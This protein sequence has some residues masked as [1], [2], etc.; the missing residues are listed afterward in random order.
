[1]KWLF[2]LLLKKS[3]ISC[4]D[5]IADREGGIVLTKPD[6]VSN[7]LW[8]FLEKMPREQFIPFFKTF[9]SIRDTEGKT[10]LQNFTILQS[11][12]LYFDLPAV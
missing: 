8:L 2:P 10:F 9:L 6:N 7:A 1:M 12:D 11:S 4:L 3:P 5:R